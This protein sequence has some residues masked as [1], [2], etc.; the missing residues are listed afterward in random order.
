[1]RTRLLLALLA[2]ASSNTLRAYHFSGHSF[3]TVRT[4]FQT[5]SPLKEAL[6]HYD[7]L[8]SCDNGIGGSLEIVP[9][10][11]RT[12]GRELGHF[13]GPLGRTE[14][15]VVEYKPGVRSSTSDVQLEKDLEA[16]HFNIKTKSS[17]HTFRSEL[18]LRPRH[19]YE[20]VGFAYRQRLWDCWWI[21]ISAPVMRVRNKVEL[22]ERIKDNGG[23]AVNELGLSG[24]PRFGSVTEAFRSNAMRYARID[25]REHEKW[26]LADIEFK[27]GWDGYNNG[28]AHFRSYIGGVFP[29]GNKPDPRFLFP[30]VVGNNKHFGVMFGGNIG[31]LICSW[32]NHLFRHEIDT[33]GR[34]LFPNHQERSF[35][36]KDKQWS[37][38]MEVY[39]DKKQAERAFTTGDSNSG[40]FGTDVFTRRVKVSPRFATIFN[41]AFIW[42]YCGFL[43]AEAG[44]NF[45][46][47]QGE[48][49]EFDKFNRSIALK[50]V[51]GRGLTTRS[52]TI[53]DN[54]AQ[55]RI[56]FEDYT[57]IEIRD[58]D[59]N[60]GAH[61]PVIAQILYGAVGVRCRQWVYP[62][63]FSVGGSYEFSHS[64]GGLRAWTVWGKAAMDF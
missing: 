63:T 30:P 57:P 47:R 56:E 15:N 62:T 51:N 23:G 42:E 18:S 22:N 34:Y 60:T 32:G 12:L 26:G 28:T 3:F 19:A 13:F 49:V 33:G 8:D 53:K 45:Y 20:G 7:V 50:H 17:T 1:M 10:G 2:V 41:T 61:P 38:Y 4:P 40:T 58:L 27:L 5:G 29:T 16:R 44:Y 25:S 55:D 46:A 14:L 59:R 39:S 54:F 9:F 31:F 11:G 6:W 24:K 21:D 37:R 52:R 36:L 43:T 64:N 35:D 48:L